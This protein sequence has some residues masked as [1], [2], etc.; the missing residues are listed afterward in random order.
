MSRYQ[1]D[2][3]GI[4]DMLCSGRMQELVTIAAERCKEIAEETA[5]I[6]EEGPHPGRYREGFR[7][8]HGVRPASG[9]RTARAFAKVVNDAPEA[10]WVE[11]GSV[12]NEAHHTLAHAL[13]ATRL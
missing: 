3:A 9:A 2:R 4:G 10:V 8:K 13:G 7:L 12:H 6:Y 1:P 5:P 11:I